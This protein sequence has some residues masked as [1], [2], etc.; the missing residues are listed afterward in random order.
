MSP[1]S[2]DMVEEIKKKEREKRDE[3]AKG[4]IDFVEKVYGPFRSKAYT[5]AVL[6]FLKLNPNETQA[7]LRLHNH[8]NTE[9]FSAVRAKLA[10][11]DLDRKDAE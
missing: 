10:N 4:Y 11:N 9:W 5:D 3:E 6:H 1:A 2:R 8:F 7:L